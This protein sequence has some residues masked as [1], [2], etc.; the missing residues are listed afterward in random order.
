MVLEA[1]SLLFIGFIVGL[2]GA[3]IPGPLLAFTIADTM[4]KG[5][6]T[7]HLVIVGHALWESV[8]IVAIL[9]GLA[10]F[11]AENAYFIYL[12]G[13][14]FLVF[15][16]LS[17]MREVKDV[18]VESSRVGSSVVGGVFYTLFN[19][20]HIPWW[21]TAGLAM[22]FKGMEMLGLLGIAL[23]VV[24]HWL[25]DFAYYIFVSLTVHKQGRYVT[26]H[27]RRISIVLSLFLVGLGLYF[28]IHGLLKLL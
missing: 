23:V 2:S 22:L 17:M 10:R 20:S 14:V 6:A 15:M 9:L 26:R 21:A 3:M 1:V 24:G 8:V 5:K 4:R 28:M 25:S 12:I 19:P 13:G 27:R 18:E 16:G 7:G 11:L